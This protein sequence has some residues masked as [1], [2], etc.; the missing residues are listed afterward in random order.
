MITGCGLIW[1]VRDGVPGLENSQG[2]YAM[3]AKLCSW[4]MQYLPYRSGILKYDKWVRKMK[5]KEIFKTGISRRVREN[6][7]RRSLIVTL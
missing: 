1:S 5:V 7:W 3:K 4:L 6:I 2:K